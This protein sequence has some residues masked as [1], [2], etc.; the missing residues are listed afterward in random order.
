MKKSLV[1]VVLVAF[2]V[3]LNSCGGDDPAPI[4]AVVG[5]WTLNTY[6][7]T[8]LPTGFSKYEGAKT[9]MLYGVESGYT[10]VVKSDGTYTRSFK[11]CCGYPS[12]SDKGKWTFENDVL[13]L[14][15]DNSDDLDLIESYGSVGLEFSVKGEISD[16]RMNLTAPFNLPLLPDSYTGDPKDAQEAD[17]KVADLTLVY[18]FDKL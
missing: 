12:I 11:M 3:T 18:V 1:W 14:S 13:K 17:Y 5:T 4:P 15:P 8:E 7:L 9:S 6:Q 10:L 16:I 2:V